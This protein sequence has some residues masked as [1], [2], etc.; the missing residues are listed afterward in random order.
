MDNASDA[1]Y[2]DAWHGASIF[3]TEKST[4]YDAD[5]WYRTSDTTYEN[6]VLSWTHVHELNKEDGDS[7]AYFAYFPPYSYERHLGLIAQCAEKKSE[8]ARVFS[9]GQTV[10]GRE[11]DCVKFGT[12]PRKCWIIHRQHPGESMASFYA[13]GLLTRL[14][15]LNDKWDTVSEKARELFTFYIVPNMNPDGSANGYLRTNAAGSNL[16]REWC[17]SSSTSGE[18]Y[19]A[20]TIHRSPEVYYLLKHMDES[21]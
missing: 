11:I 19:D 17:P 2:A 16:N 8:G 20:P 15:G 4:P 5:S 7:S 12:G 21:G 13:E 1:S 9:L 14:L 10:E 18:L 3:V 6:G